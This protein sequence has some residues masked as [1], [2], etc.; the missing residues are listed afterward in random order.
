MALIR[1]TPVAGHRG[2]ATVA[3]AVIVLVAGIATGALRTRDAG[4]T[5]STSVAHERPQ[6]GWTVATSSPRGVMVDYRNISVGG[7]T[8]RALRLRARTTL[9][10]W[11]VGSTDPNSVRVPRDAGPAIDWPSEGPPGVVAV[12][13]G[14]FKQA[15]AAGGSA[16]DGIALSPLMKSHMTIALNA[17]G[18]WALGLW[19]SPHFPPRDF[20]AIAYRQNLGPVVWN[21]ALSA[22]ATSGNSGQWGSPLGGVAAEPRTGLGVDAKGNLIYVATMQP[23]LVAALGRAMI[24]AGVVMGMELDINP[25][26]PILGAPFRP[27]HATGGFFPVQLPRS[28]H[29]P[30]I[31]ETGWTRDFFVAVAEPASWSCHWSSSGLHEPFGSVPQPQPLHLVGRCFVRGAATT[32]T[33][34]P[35][36]TTTTSTVTPTPSS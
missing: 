7:V 13:N 10:R 1:R 8:F 25:Y 12:F 35:R 22:A 5:T 16:A 18:H 11:H 21:H 20:R 30:S 36:I 33:T 14:A 9:L 23:I 26:W 24:A 27:L 2:A 19:G 6:P 28:E 31:Y 15:A 17:T 34:T 4:S 3:V 29:N 32:T